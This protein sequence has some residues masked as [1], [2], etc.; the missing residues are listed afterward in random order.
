MADLLA[1]VLVTPTLQE[2]AA[3]EGY[4]ARNWRGLGGGFVPFG[5]HDPRRTAVNGYLAEMV[6]ARI[7]GVPWT[8]RDGP[9]G[10]IDLVWLGLGVQVKWN[11]YSYGD[12]YS[13]P[14]LPITA[15][16]LVLVV[17]CWPDSRM[18]IVG[19]LTRDEY[20]RLRQSR[21]YG[22][23]N[24]VLAVAQQWLH[25]IGRLFGGEGARDG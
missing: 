6:V 1:G 3:A 7:L 17:P 24:T 25:P 18:R 2:V 22:R 23:G 10:G 20:L 12:L 8:G 19:Y 15:D 14:D 4:V 16:L 13:R 9:D 11:S 21:S 5:D